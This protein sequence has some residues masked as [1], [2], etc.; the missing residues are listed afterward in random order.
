MLGRLIRRTNLTSRARRFF[1]AVGP[2][3]R[4][5]RDMS[6][7]IDSGLRLTLDTKFGFRQNA[8]IFRCKLCFNSDATALAGDDARNASLR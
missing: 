1:L 7:A 2:R 8:A 4:A 5:N 3:Q 6:R